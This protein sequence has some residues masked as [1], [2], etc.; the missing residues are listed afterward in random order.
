M[1]KNEFKYK[2]ALSELED[3]LHEIENGEP[4]LDSLSEK[5]KR[6]TFLI[7]ECK[8]RLRKTSEEIDSILEDWES[9]E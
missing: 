7:K 9:G 5:V 2:D 8:T 1:T 3:I 4:D 6:A